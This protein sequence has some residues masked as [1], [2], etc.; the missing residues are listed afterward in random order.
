VHENAVIQQKLDPYFK[1]FG[2][3]VPS[4][5]SKPSDLRDKNVVMTFMY[6]GSSVYHTKAVQ[7]NS[8]PN[9]RCKLKQEA[10]LLLGDRATFV[11]FEYVGM[12]S[13]DTVYP[14]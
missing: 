10:H 9:S 11:S 14:S 1:K 7:I 12:L 4:E 3:F 8:R 6:S 5:L 13:A 2:A